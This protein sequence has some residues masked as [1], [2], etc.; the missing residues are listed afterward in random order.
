[1][2]VFNMLLLPSDELLKNSENSRRSS[3]YWGTWCSFNLVDPL[4][5]SWGFRLNRC[6]SRSNETAT[7]LY[8]QQ[9]MD[10]SIYVLCAVAP[11]CHSVPALFVVSVKI[12]ALCWRAKRNQKQQ[13]SKWMQKT[14][15]N[16]C[17]RKTGSTFKQYD[18]LQ[19][20]FEHWPKR[21]C[22]CC[23]FF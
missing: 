18:S 19:W 9:T 15:K 21:L 1:M 22:C 2:V 13:I 10:P 12:E 11:S 14:Q 20:S 3:A 7:I 6:I 4:L 23:F 17:F 8:L 5:L 16:V